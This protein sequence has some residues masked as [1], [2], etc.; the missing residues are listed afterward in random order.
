M[1]DVRL[2]LIAA[3]ATHVFV[4][5]VIEDDGEPWMAR[6]TDVW[7]SRGVCSI[8]DWSLQLQGPS[9]YGPLLLGSTYG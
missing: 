7:K 5:V 8:G 3:T 9:T 4:V 6:R 1:Q 2:A